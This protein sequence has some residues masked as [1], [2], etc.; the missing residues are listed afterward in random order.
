MVSGTISTV[1]II[2]TLLN[3]TACESS[4]RTATFETLDSVKQVVNHHSESSRCDELEQCASLRQRNPPELDLLQTFQSCAGNNANF[5]ISILTMPF[6]SHH[7]DNAHRHEP[8][9]D[10]SQHTL[11]TGAISGGGGCHYAVTRSYLEGLSA[12]GANFTFNPPLSVARS[13]AVLWV[14]AGAHTL[15]SALQY[16]STDFGGE[17]VLVVAGPNVEMEALAGPGVD[18]AL[19]PSGWVQRLFT[20]KYR[21]LS[22]Q[23]VALPAGVCTEYWKPSSSGKDKQP[24]RTALV[25]D[26]S[27]VSEASGLNHEVV[28]EVIAALYEAQY[29]VELLSYAHPGSPDGYSADQYRAALS[30]SRVLVWLSASESQGIALAEAW[31]MDAPTVV[32]ASASAVIDGYTV[33]GT[34]PAPYLTDATGAWL[35]SVEELGQ[36]LRDIEE[37]RKGRGPREWVIRHMSDLAA[38]KMVLDVISCTLHNRTL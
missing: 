24:A 14:M 21:H 29:E 26:K 15:A 25:Y 13:S 35:H 30:V 8:P 1:V 18:L 9:I 36:V 11:C 19:F 16:R 3:L 2:T 4:D 32:L 6:S 34:S 23:S 10:T 33:S 12:L 31:A 27:L 5:Q 38:A 22:A 17:N 37:G 20:S 28:G 7:D